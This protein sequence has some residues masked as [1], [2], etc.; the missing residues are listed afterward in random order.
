MSGINVQISLTLKQNI[1]KSLLNQTE[2]ILE[3]ESLKF[4]TYEKSSMIEVKI[5]L[6]GGTCNVIIICNEEREYCSIRCVLPNKIP[7]SK[8]IAVAELFNRFN[9]Q[10]I[11]GSFALD[12]EDGEMYYQQSIMTIENHLEKEVFI[13][14]LRIVLNTVND[15]YNK[16]MSVIFG[17]VQPVLAALEMAN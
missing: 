5:Q 4:T 1:M 7:A 3:A 9:H 8:K 16:I 15:Q 13:R 14:T 12:M 10:F 17:N 11:F 2:Q 6:D